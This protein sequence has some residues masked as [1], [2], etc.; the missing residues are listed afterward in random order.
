MAPQELNTTD[1]VIDPATGEPEATPAPESFFKR[2]TRQL[3]SQVDLECAR[4]AEPF[5][6]NP[7]SDG[8]CSRCSHYA[9]VPGDAPG[10][11]NWYQKHN[12]GAWTVR[13]LWEDY[14]YVGEGRRE[15]VELELP[16]EGDT[17]DVYRR[18]GTSSR[19]T[20][21]RVGESFLAPN[22]CRYLY[23]QVGPAGR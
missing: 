22:A 18:D 23:C 13:A 3:K 12:D 16:R 7:E 20:V 5:R 14:R 6:G 19:Q 21:A 17:I 8:L 15:D 11:F 4:C 10:A 2:I 9:S 1:E